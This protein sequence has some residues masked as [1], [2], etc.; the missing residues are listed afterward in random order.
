MLEHTEKNINTR[1][2]ALRNGQELIVS[3]ATENDAKELIELMKIMDGETKFL[4]RE[5]EE[6]KLTIEQEVSFLNSINN[7][8]NAMFIVAELDGIIVGNCSVSRISNT[9]RYRHRASMGIA[10][11]KSNWG[12]GIGREMMHSCIVWCEKNGIE[13]LELEVVS[14]NTRAISMYESIGFIRHG[15]KKNALKYSNG[16]YADE[17]FMILDLKDYSRWE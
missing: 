3:R 12:L 4:A 1:K 15:I 8:P 11:R 7:N 9:L 5:P 6:F 10:V 13:Q 2:L 16:E 17:Y 14:E